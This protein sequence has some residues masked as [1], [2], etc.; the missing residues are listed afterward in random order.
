MYAKVIINAIL[1]TLIS[2]CTALGL[3]FTTKG[4]SNFSD[5][6]QVSYGYAFI[7]SLAAGLVIL[8]TSLTDSPANIKQTNEIVSAM[9]AINEISPDSINLPEK[10]T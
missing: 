2:L 4:I 1:T 7:I 10:T 5:I 8:K 9:A 3:L 6:S